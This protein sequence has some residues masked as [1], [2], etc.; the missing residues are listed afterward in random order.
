[1]KFALPFLFLFIAIG[2][3]SWLKLLADD[4]NRAAH[5]RRRRP[6]RHSSRTSIR[7]RTTITAPFRPGCGR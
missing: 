7:P 1:V 2:A 4:L 3:S 6:E 5:R